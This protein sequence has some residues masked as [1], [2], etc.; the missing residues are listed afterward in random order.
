MKGESLFSFSKNV[1]KLSYI[2][3]EFK[4]FPGDNTPDPRFRGRGK[5]VLVLRKCTKTLLLRQQCRIQNFS[6]EQNP[7]LH[8][9][10]W[11]RLFRS[12]KMYWNSPTA[13][14]NSKI[15]P[16]TILRTPVLGEESL[17]SYSVN[18]L[19][20]FYNNAEFK[21]SPRDNTPTPVLWAREV[22]FCSPKM[23]QNSP[24][25]MQNS[26][27]NPVVEPPDPRFGK[28]RWK[29]PPLEIMSGYATDY[30]EKFPRR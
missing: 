8:F 17:F 23:Y 20:L 24:T 1:L 29:M 13:M 19:K 22:C 10:G 4:N 2:N 18:V 15:F 27:K 14:Q 11:G 7:D 30:D 26:K 9:R 3:A 28:G 25:V 16:G 6:R 12:P 21:N 5:F